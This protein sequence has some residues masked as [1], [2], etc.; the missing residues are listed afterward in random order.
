[1]QSKIVHWD[2]N[3]KAAKLCTD[4]C[5]YMPEKVAE[6]LVKDKVARPCNYERYTIENCERTCG[7]ISSELEYYC[8]EECVYDTYND[9]QFDK[10]RFL[11]D[12]S[13]GAYGVEPPNTY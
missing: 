7:D 10:D 8:V 6:M 11:E 13:K 5:I 3:C 1:M 4:N 2:K 12:A 9:E